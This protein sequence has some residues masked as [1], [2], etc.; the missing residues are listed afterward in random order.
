MNN[1]S[2]LMNNCSQLMNDFCCEGIV[3]PLVKGT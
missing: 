1:C 3:V 2:K